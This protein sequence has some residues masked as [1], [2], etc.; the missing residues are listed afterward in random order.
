VEDSLWR[1]SRAAELLK[2][3]VVMFR[4][5]RI[6]CVSLRVNSSE[7]IPGGHGD[8]MLPVAGENAC[9]PRA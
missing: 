2:Q 8:D 3:G 9:Q 4:L 5:T 7:L 1:Q 6:D